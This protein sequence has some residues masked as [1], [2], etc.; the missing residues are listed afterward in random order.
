MFLSMLKM[1]QE[2]E[3]NLT[4]K[5][6]CEDSDIMYMTYENAYQ[7]IRYVFRDGKCVGVYTEPMC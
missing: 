1:I 7:R 4:L 6:S 5:P 3:Q 2:L